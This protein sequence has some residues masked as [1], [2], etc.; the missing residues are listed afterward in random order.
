MISA[1]AIKS[2]AENAGLPAFG[3]A[4]VVRRTAMAEAG[5]NTCSG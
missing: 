2:L 4:G 5:A 3:R 1:Q